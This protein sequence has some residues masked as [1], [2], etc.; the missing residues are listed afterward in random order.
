MLPDECDAVRMRTPGRAKPFVITEPRVRWNRRLNKYARVFLLS[1]FQSSPPPRFPFPLLCILPLVYNPL[2]ACP[3]AAGGF[4]FAN[5]HDD[6]ACLQIRCGSAA[7][8]PG[9]G[10]DFP[11]RRGSGGAREVHIWYAKARV[12]AMGRQAA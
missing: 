12:R 7:V 10:H 9:Q 2:I 4:V 3:C 6:L 8:P 11:G 1:P 5:A